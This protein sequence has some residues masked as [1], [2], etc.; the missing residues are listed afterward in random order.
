MAV[1]TEINETQLNEFL[2]CYFSHYKVTRFE[3]I[4]AGIENSNFWLDVNL[5]GKASHWVLTVFEMS[6]GKEL[7]SIVRLMQHLANNRLPVPAPVNDQHGSAIRE[8]VSKPSLLVPKASGQYIACPGADE[9]HQAGRF[10]GRMHQVSQNLKCTIPLAR[11]A[12]WLRQRQKDILRHGPPA[13]SQAD[14]SLLNDEIRYSAQLLTS[15]SRC[16]TGWIH[17]DLFVDN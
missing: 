16:P 11:D 6:D 7:P 2:A 15:M 17:G 9:C 1:F 5:A 8:L 14:Q 3:G 13:L 4:T 12:H 10:L